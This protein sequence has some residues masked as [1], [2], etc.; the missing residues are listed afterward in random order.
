MGFIFLSFICFKNCFCRESQTHNSTLPDWGLYEDIWNPADYNAKLHRCMKEIGHTPKYIL[1]FRD[2]RR[3]FPK[4]ALIANPNITFVVSLEL[5]E[6]ENPKAKYLEKIITGKYDAFFL[7]WAKEAAESKKPF[8]LRFGFEMQGKWF[9]WGG[10]PELFRKA[11]THVHTLFKT[12][13][14]TNALWLFSP[15]VLFN[16]MTDEKDIAP[17]YPGDSLVD[18]VGLDGYNFGDNHDNYHKWQSYTEVFEHSIVAMAQYS[19]PLIISE[20]GC[21]DDA[22]KAAWMN[23][24]LNRVSKDKRVSGFVYFNYDKRSEGE[25]NWA[26]N[27]DPN[28]YRVFKNWLKAYSNTPQYPPRSLQ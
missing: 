26:L 20:I 12:A 15:N 24:F 23:D 18:Y 17:Y 8:L 6:W 2:L 7:K 5:H 4:E 27:S 25:P 19:K 9:S 13:G 1:C 10:Q 22:R 11:W 3:P 28:S 14:A 21:A 16:S